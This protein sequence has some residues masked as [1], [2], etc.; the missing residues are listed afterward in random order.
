MVLHAAGKDLGLAE[1]DAECFE[2]MRI[3][4]G[5]PVFGRDITEK[6][7]PQEI[8]RDDRAI[9][10]VKGCYLG[11]ETVA[12]I[13]AL[14]HVNQVLTGLQ[15]EQSAAC[16]A[17]G[18]SLVAE[19]KRVGF[20]TSSTFSPGWNRA[21]ALAMIR[22]THSRPGTEVIVQEPG[23]QGQASAAVSALPL[24]PHA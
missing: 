9:N 22:V 24:L 4:A 18:A 13:D 6:N 8:G 11:Q 21:I 19:G 7:L 17:P 2:V 12:R 5:T 16:P 23:G 20:V 1:V 3:E 10:F 15:F 14:G